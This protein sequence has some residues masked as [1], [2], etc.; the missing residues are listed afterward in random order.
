MKDL[1]Q[2]ECLEINGGNFT[3]VAGWL[4]G[5]VLFDDLIPL[6]FAGYAKVIAD[7]YH[8]VLKT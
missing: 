2:K 6:N 7:Y 4:L 8:D 5:H 1:N 3:F